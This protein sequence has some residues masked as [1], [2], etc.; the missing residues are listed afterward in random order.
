MKYLLSKKSIL[1]FLFIVQSIFIQNI[2]A[3]DVVKLKQMLAIIKKNL[4][5]KLL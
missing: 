4:Q 2:P 1:L 3:Q 5:V